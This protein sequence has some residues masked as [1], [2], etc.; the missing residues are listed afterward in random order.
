MDAHGGSSGQGSAGGGEHGGAAGDPSAAG[1]GGIAGGAAAGSGGSG[2][3]GAS[4]TGGAKAAAEFSLVVRSA[5]ATRLIVEI[6]PSATGSAAVLSRELLREPGTERWKV[7]IPGE[8]LAAAGLAEP[9]L[10]GIRAWGPNWPFDPAWSPGSAAGFVEDVDAEGNRFNP[11]KLLIDPYAR[12]ISHD[13]TTPEMPSG[14]VYQTGAKHRSEDSGPFAPKGIWRPSTPVDVAPRPTRPLK[15]DV[16]YEVH[17][18]GFTKNDPSIKEACRG[19]YAGA[20]EK[21]D[22]LKSLGV[23]AVEFLP[24]QETS[25]SKNDIEASTSGDNYW[26]YSTIAYFA[27]DRRYA[28]DTSPGGPT[29]EF[30]EM[31]RAMHQRGIKVYLDVVYNH[32]AEGGVGDPTTATLLSLRGLDNAGYYELSADKKHYADNNG[33]GANTNAPSS[34]FRALVID[35]LKYLH[36]DLGVD[37]FRFD[38][39]SVLGN[40]CEQTCFQFDS[41]DPNGLLKQL[42]QELPARPE[43]GGE[44]VDLIAEPWGIGAG[45]YQL[46][47]FPGGWSEWNGAFRDTLRKDMNQLDVTDVTPRQILFAVAG[48]PDRYA[49][50]G[51]KPAASINFLVSHDGFTLRDLFSCTAKNNNQPWPYGPS[52]GGEDNNISWNYGADPVRQRQAAR[53]GLALLMLSAGV[54][55]ITGGDELYRTLQCNNNAYNLDAQ[56]NWLDWSLSATFPHHATFVREL[57]R[58]RNQHPALRPAH[59]PV[60]SDLDKNGVDDWAFLTDKGTP[61]SDAYLDNPANHFLA[62]RVDGGPQKD[63]ARSIYVAYNGVNFKVEATLPPT[64]PGFAWYHVLDTSDWFEDKDNIVPENMEEIYDHPSY[65]VG[66][67]AVAVFVE[68][69]AP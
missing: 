3:S 37:G 25:N 32:T 57:L 47:A 29:R 69:P 8:E 46:G 35:S 23:T 65:G 22:Y 19:T 63:E 64:A 58:F 17:V 4:G 62:W 60:Q 20:A 14:Q 34:L 24:V 50:D 27:P 13:P 45:T 33:V 55:M 15:D 54:P 56:T 1:T 28:C 36:D 31:V 9:L 49:D 66:R 41:Q 38:L 67:R 5:R 44:G 43:A 42:T 6:F 26:G 48:S 18:R 11:N 59:W 61:T 10:Y 52:D 68:R 21:A 2:T 51:R 12:E 30:A 53:T 7:S 39:A 40:K 16:I